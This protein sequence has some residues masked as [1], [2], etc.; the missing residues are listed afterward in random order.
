MAS[1]T[2]IL[3]GVVCVLWQEAEHSWLLHLLWTLCMLDMVRLVST[4]KRALQFFLGSLVPPHNLLPSANKV[5]KRLH[6]V[7]VLSLYVLA[8]TWGGLSHHETALSWNC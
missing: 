4:I 7:N 8:I 1:G 6:C 2:E 3:H 5:E